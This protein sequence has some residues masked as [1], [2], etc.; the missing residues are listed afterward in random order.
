LHLLFIYLMQNISMLIRSVWIPTY[1][2][3]WIIS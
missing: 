2:S 1:W 3:F